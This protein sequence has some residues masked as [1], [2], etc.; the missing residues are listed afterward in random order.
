MSTRFQSLAAA[1]AVATLTSTLSLSAAEPGFQS[2][3]D[4]TTLNGWEGHAGIWSVQDGTITGKTTAETKLGHNTFLVWKGG[5]VEDF[6][7]RLSYRIVNGNSG[8]QY[9]SKVVEQ[10]AQGPIVGGYQA[11]FEAGKTY[12]GILYEER[13]RGI[14]AQRGQLTRIVAAEGGK[15]AV[16][17]V[18]SL[19]KTEDIQTGI[20]SEDWN[21]YVVLARG[22]R[23]THIINGRVTSEVIDDDAAHAAKSGVLAF[24]VHVGPPMTVQFKNVQLKSLSGGAAT[25][26]AAAADTLSSMQGEWVCAKG[27]YDGQELGADI[28]SSIVMK[29]SGNKY[30]VRW[31]D[32]SDRGTLKVVE[33]ATPKQLII[34]SD[35]NGQSQGIL[36]FEGQN[37]KIAYGLNGGAR[38]GD[39]SGGSSSFSAVYRRK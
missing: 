18:G 32:G 20:K 4:G 22:N 26:A 28:A 36:A 12:S 37:L 33:G 1:V 11:D 21:D 7:L 5:T 39:F 6:E 3:F 38:P 19:G 34:E 9:R 27:I 15:H 16:E 31:A 2:L 8:I 35:S 29:I 24:Q 13:G 17:V 25:A 30:D 23:L 10:G 14:L